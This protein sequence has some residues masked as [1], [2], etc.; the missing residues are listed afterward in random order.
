MIK[1]KNISNGFWDEAISIVVYLK[2]RS[3][4]K[5][6]EH[7]TP[8]EYFYGYKPEVSHLRIFG[9]K[10]FAHIPKEDRRKLDAKEIKCIFIGYCTYHKAYKMFD[11]STHKVF[12]RRDVLFHENV[13]EVPKEDGYDV[14]H[15]P[16]ENEESAK[17]EDEQ[18]QG[19]ASSIMDPT[20]SQSMPRRGGGTPQ[21]NE[22][23]RRTTRQSK[24]PVRYKDYALMT[25]V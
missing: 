6:L 25:Q 20:S 13:D 7:K 14:W 2:N 4:T 21:S 19:E 24:T 18:V 1:G 17:E 22:E 15:L 5:I 8:F 23:L 11:P 12:A 3:P 16:K 10:A 9:S